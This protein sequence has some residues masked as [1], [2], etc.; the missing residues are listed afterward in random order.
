VF[1]RELLTNG[2]RAS[3]IGTE[4]VNRERAELEIAFHDVPSLILSNAGMS[5]SQLRKE[6]VLRFSKRVAA[7]PAARE[8]PTRTGYTPASP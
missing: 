3:S 6:D 2:T 4:G 1:L 7:S 5:A 8:D